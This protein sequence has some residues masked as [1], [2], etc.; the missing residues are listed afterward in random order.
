MK[1]EGSPLPTIPDYGISKSEDS[2]YLNQVD[3]S[4]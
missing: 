3:D 2:D 1:T 4:K